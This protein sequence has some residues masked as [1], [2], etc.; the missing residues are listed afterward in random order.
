MYYIYKIY[1][2]VY[3]YYYY[4]YNVIY[5]NIITYISISIYEGFK[6]IAVKYLIDV[7]LVK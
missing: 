1:I 3:C 5:I 4:I 6:I 7:T 2:N